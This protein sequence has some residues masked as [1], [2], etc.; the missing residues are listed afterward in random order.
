MYLII[1]LDSKKKYHKKRPHMRGAGW[2]GTLFL[3]QF[4]RNCNPLSVAQTWLNSNTTDSALKIFLYI[5]IY[6]LYIFILK[7]WNNFVILKF[8][9]KNL[10]YDFKCF[11]SFYLL[12][13]S[14]TVSF[15]RTLLVNSFN[16]WINFI[17]S[18]ELCWG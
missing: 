15:V 3:N 10:I 12:K 2:W 13:I 9:S 5:F 7:F 14:C 6:I 1:F 4:L 17:N 11:W 18:F 8:L 16:D